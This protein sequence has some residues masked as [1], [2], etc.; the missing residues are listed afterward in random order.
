MPL[1][2][3]ELDETVLSRSPIVVAI[4]Q[5]RYE[6]NLRVSDGDTGL[7]IH[8]QL[9]GQ[10]GPYPTIEPMQAMT[11][12]IEVGPSGF[13][14][15]SAAPM[16]GIQ[17]RGWRLKSAD[18]AWT[19]AIM[20]DNVS[21]ETTAYTQWSE[22][23]EPR[24]IRLLEIIADQIKPAVAERIGLRYVNRL[25]EPK[26]TEPKDWIDV[27]AP[28][29]LG[30]VCNSFWAAGIRNIQQQ[31]D[32]DAGDGAHCLVRH[33]FVPSPKGDIDGYALDYDVFRQ[34]PH[35]FDVEDIGEAV[36]Q[37]HRIALAIFQKSL[38]PTYLA[39]LR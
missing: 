12:Q 4:C 24:F 22:D 5:V 14:L 23:F 34:I 28:E 6:Q 36:N 37:F 10:Q 19:V 2:L 16:P 27:V 7:T 13:G 38:A 3:P 9:G 32:L 31:L 20:P 35:R 25:N 11:A 30:P 39:S 17:S 1:I 33:G 15:A 21:I 18:A 29:L 26:L 8:E